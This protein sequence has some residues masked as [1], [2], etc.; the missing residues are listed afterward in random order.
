[1]TTIAIPQLQAD[2]QFKAYLLKILA[3][4]AV[5][6][7]KVKAVLRSRKPKQQNLPL[8]KTIVPVLEMPYWKLRPDFK[9]RD[10]KRYAIKKQTIQQLQAAWQDTPSAEELI[11]HL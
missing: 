2:E 9:P 3:E 4:D 7:I 10:G 8:A 6:A 5:F 1:M 11:A